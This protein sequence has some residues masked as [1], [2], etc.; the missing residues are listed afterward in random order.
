MLA[1]LRNLRFPGSPVRRNAMHNLHSADL[2]HKMRQVPQLGPQYAVEPKKDGPGL[3]CHVVEVAK[4]LLK[5][6]S[7]GCMSRGADVPNGNVG[8]RNKPAVKKYIGPP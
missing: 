1:R 4:R 8:T 5:C 3:L 6:E 2:A 7:N